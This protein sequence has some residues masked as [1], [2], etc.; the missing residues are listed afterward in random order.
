MLT[1]TAK[2]AGRE[3]GMHKIAASD[4]DETFLDHTHAVPQANVDA[5]RELRERV[6]LRGV[7]NASGGAYR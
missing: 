7:A 2:T 1:E 6:P 3:I 4:M 5:V